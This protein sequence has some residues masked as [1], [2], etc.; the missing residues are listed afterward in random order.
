MNG[1]FKH[2]LLNDDQYFEKFVKDDLKQL[3]KHI[4]KEKN[5]STGNQIASLIK[6]I[7]LRVDKK[8]N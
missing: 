7:I 4:L 2:M 1:I 5:F 6:L 3:L 8:N